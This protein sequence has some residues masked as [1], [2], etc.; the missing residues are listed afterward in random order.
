MDNAQTGGKVV[1]GKARQRGVGEAAKG[2]LRGED[3]RVTEGEE[4]E[5]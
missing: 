3:V 4:M 1:T 5:R 2:G